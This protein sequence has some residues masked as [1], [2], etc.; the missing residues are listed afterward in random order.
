MVLL[1][2]DPW[3][4]AVDLYSILFKRRTGVA[5]RRFLKPEETKT[6]RRSESAQY[7]LSNLFEAKA[8]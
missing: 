8:S 4:V 5:S 3:F 7:A 1:N 6:F 2:G